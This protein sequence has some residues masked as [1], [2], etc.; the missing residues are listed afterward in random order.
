MNLLRLIVVAAAVTAACGTDAPT[1]YRAEN[2]EAFMAACV[3]GPVDG[4]YQ[5]RVCQCVYDEAEATMPFERFLEINDQLSD[6]DTAVLPE[7]LVDLVAACV[8]EEG[9]L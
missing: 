7:D 3:D 8:I 1:E 6:V 2:Q 5:Q 9:D 4:I